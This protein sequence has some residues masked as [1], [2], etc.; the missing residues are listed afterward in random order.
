MSN[1]ITSVGS[2]WEPVVRF[3]LEELEQHAE[4][5]LVAACAGC[6]GCRHCSVVDCSAP[7]D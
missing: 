1:V 3:E 2:D 6:S 7:M 4:R 5:N